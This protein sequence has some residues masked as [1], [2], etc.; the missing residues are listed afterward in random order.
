MSHSHL[1]PPRSLVAALWSIVGL[2]AVFIAV[3]FSSIFV[4]RY[5]YPVSAEVITTKSSS[6]G[7][8]EGEEKI[9]INNYPGLTSIT[10]Y[11]P[12][13]SPDYYQHG[14]ILQNTGGNFQCSQICVPGLSKSLADTKQDQQKVEDYLKGATIGGKEVNIVD[15]PDIFMALVKLTNET[16]DTNLKQQ[17]QDLLKRT[18][19]KSATKAGC[20]R[21]DSVNYDKIEKAGKEVER[22][23]D[24]KTA[25]SEA[26][27]AEQQPS[28]EKPATPPEL[29]QPIA[30]A[31]KNEVQLPVGATGNNNKASLDQCKEDVN[32]FLYHYRNIND[33][34]PDDPL[35]MTY[36]KVEAE[37]KELKKDEN[38][39]SALK[40][41]LELKKL[42]D[43]ATA[44]NPKLAQ[45]K[46]DVNTFIVS[47]EQELKKK[48]ETDERLDI[49]KQRYRSL[50]L[51]IFAKKE[52]LLANCFNIKDTILEYKR[53][54]AA[55]AVSKDPFAVQKQIA[56]QDAAS[57]AQQEK[58]L[59]EQEERRIAAESAVFWS[60]PSWD[61]ANF[62][63]LRRKF[64]WKTYNKALGLEATLVKFKKDSIPFWSLKYKDHYYSFGMGYW[65]PAKYNVRFSGLD[66]VG[67]VIALPKPFLDKYY[68]TN[69]H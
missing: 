18:V 57:K 3:A 37:Y 4:L 31:A 64:T 7:C 38:E 59:R 5:F 53:I 12:K 63:G 24:E 66:P 11:Y 48:G 20:L 2:V 41:C 43:D 44:E 25:V 14:Q 26:Q 23:P 21:T 65:T 9:A 49:V 58:I 36:S 16:K 54:L 50:K 69:V 19:I 45:C 32:D 22:E 34:L 51:S 1:E 52:N 55:E 67:Q 60:K 30:G 61:V 68:Q 35:R 6:E 47:R 46:K 56:A 28:E 15:N 33:T 29:P 8:A 13:T 17:Y 39:D 40:K 62:G 27:K 10:K 42:A